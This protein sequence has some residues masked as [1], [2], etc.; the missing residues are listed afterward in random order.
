MKDKNLKF[1]MDELRSMQNR[2]G[3]E[4]EQ[5]SRLEAAME[6]LRRLWRKPNPSR[7][8]VYR[9]VRKVAEAILGTFN[10]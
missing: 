9:A 6:E 1:C 10:K 8:H 3:L 4:P 5:R 7:K 2:S